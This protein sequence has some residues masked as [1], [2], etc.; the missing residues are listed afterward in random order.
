MRKFVAAAVLV[1]ALL[2]GLAWAAPSKD[3]TYVFNRTT[4]LSANTDALTSD[5]TPSV[6]TSLYRVWVSPGTSSV[7]NY[8]ADDGTTTKTI[9]LNESGALNAND[10][11]VF[12]IPCV[13][14][15]TYNFQFETTQSSGYPLLF[16]QEIQQ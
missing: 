8:T 7:F 15:L 12:D 14:G 2:V 11:Y 5:L 9:G 13:K 4:S 10:Q 6:R 3:Q 1:V 16:V